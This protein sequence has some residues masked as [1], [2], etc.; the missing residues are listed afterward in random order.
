MQLHRFSNKQARL[1][2]PSCPR[3]QPRASNLT[4]LPDK[5]VILEKELNPHNYKLTEEQ[6]KNLQLLLKVMNQF[7]ATYGKPMIITSGVRDWEH[8][9]AIYKKLN[10][11]PPKG[12]AHLQAAA[13][14]VSDRDGKLA[15]Y[16]LDNI[17]LLK[18]LGLYIEDPSCTFGWIHFQ[19]IPPK[20]GNTVFIP[21]IKA[22]KQR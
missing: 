12:S 1:D 17:P 11:Q 22:A 14:D 15:A 16:C 2:P 20:S 9:A 3:T 7:R 4:Q 18:K 13:C 19:I 21:F 5:F 10:R 8:H 6:K